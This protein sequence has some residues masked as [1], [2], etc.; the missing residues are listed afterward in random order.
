MRQFCRRFH[1]VLSTWAF[2]QGLRQGTLT[3]LLRALTV[4][5]S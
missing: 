2:A 5:L 1:F 4:S 3:P